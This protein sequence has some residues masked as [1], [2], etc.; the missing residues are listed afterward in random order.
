MNYKITDF[1]YKISP[2]M[3]RKLDLI[4]R[5][6][7]QDDAWIVVDGDEGSG[8]TNMAAFLM[9]YFHCQTG[10]P[11]ETD[12]SLFFFDTNDLVNYLKS[13]QEWWNQS[14]LNLIKFSMTGRKKHHILILCIPKIHKL[15]DTIWERTV[16]MIHMHTGKSKRNKGDYLWLTRRGIRKFMRLWGKKKIRAYKKFSSFAYNGHMGHIPYVLNKVI[17]IKAYDKKKDEAI[18]NIGVKKGS[19]EKQEVKLMKKKC[20]MLRPPIE[21]RQELADKLEITIQTLNLWAKSL[22]NE[23]LDAEN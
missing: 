19:K 4:I 7:D 6:L 15:K 20:G 2:H 18:F 8:K 21:T 12:A 9:Y 11:F 14:Q 22:E 10:R 5:T 17:D 3:K 13:T 16:A 1:P 23:G